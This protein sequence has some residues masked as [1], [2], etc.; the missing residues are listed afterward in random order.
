MEWA[1]GSVIEYKILNKE[2]DLNDAHLL[3]IRC[4][5]VFTDEQAAGKAG[6]PT[7]GST[8]LPG[9]TRETATLTLTHHEWRVLFMWAENWAGHCDRT[10]PK[11]A[12]DAVRGIMREAKRQQPDMPGLSLMDEFK[13]VANMSGVTNVEVHNADGTVTPIPP[14]TKH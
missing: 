9:D 3:C 1:A 11:T 14:D 2:I 12:A 8:G 4:R 6:C 13:E 5:G 7:C 10:G